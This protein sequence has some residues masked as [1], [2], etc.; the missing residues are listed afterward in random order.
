MGKS[1]KRFWK[2]RRLW[3]VAASVF[4]LSGL[5]WLALSRLY[6]SYQDHEHLA[7]LRQVHHGIANPT[8]SRL[9]IIA[10][11]GAKVGDSKDERAIG[12]TASAIERGAK[13][14]S[15]WIETDILLSGDRVLVVFHDEKID[16]KTSGKGQ[17]AE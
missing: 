2:R 3:V 8:G 4:L 14:G 6:F 7:R 9:N 12:K 17:V 5:L 16:Y 15:D 11:R 1:K 13:S 10:H